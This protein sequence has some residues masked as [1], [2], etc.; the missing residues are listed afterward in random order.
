MGSESFASFRLN[1]ALEATLT[2][3][4]WRG[5]FTEADREAMADGLATIRKAMVQ[6][7][8]ATRGAK[9]R[10]GPLPR[11]RHG[12]RVRRRGHAGAGLRDVP[13]A[14]GK[15]R[16]GGLRWVSATTTSWRT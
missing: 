12:R 13:V 1:P 14:L 15:A 7:V 10:Q 9:G 16:G 4:G 3:A 5:G 8:G 11:L 6:P 2:F